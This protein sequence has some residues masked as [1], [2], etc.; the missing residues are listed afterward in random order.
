[1]RVDAVNADWA[2]NSR[3]PDR[4]N[5]IC[6]TIGYLFRFWSSPMAVSTR[7]NIDARETL[8]IRLRSGDRGLIDRAAAA[9]GKNRTDFVLDSVRQAAQ[10]ALLDQTFFTLDTRSYQDF[11]RLLDARPEPSDALSRTMRGPSPWK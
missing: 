6:T 5:D 11:L 8:N 4:C 3:H 2:I 1:M 10:D 7:K 9:Q